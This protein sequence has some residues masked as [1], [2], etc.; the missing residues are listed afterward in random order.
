MSSFFGRFLG[1]HPKPT[2]TGWLGHVDVPKNSLTLVAVIDPSLRQFLIGLRIGRAAIR[3]TAS[4]RRGVQN[5]V[6]A[7][8]LRTTM[9]VANPQGAARFQQ[10]IFVPRVVRATNLFDCGSLLLFPK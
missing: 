10:L 5:R 4:S 2:A 9:T 1:C 6:R 3:A 8:T 7:S